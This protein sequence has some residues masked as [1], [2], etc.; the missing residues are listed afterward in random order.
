MEIESPLHLGGPISTLTGVEGN[1]VVAM[2]M[3]LD[4]H[5]ITH[6]LQ[7]RCPF[8]MSTQFRSADLMYNALHSTLPLM[9][10]S[11]SLSLALVR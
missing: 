11:L 3:V 1:M 9:S 4:P 6:Q 10:L 7:Y 5:L 8:R 2:E